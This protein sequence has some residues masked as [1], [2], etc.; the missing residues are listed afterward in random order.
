M[1]I[2]W[3]L[4]KKNPSVPKTSLP[5]SDEIPKPTDHQ[6]S[7]AIDRLTMILAT[8]APT[9]FWREK[10]ISSSRNPA[11]I[12]KTRTQPIITQVTSSSPSRG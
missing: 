4:W 3:P 7:V 12:S 9:F 1:P 8:P 10:P 5:V 2:V 11:C 6:A